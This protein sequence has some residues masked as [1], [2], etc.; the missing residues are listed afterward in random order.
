MEVLSIL[1]I[2]RGPTVHGACTVPGIVH[3]SI[4]AAMFI[5]QGYHEISM[6]FTSFFDKL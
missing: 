1:P 5:Y 4:S 6:Q 2:N 3:S